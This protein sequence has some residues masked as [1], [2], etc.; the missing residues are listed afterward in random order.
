MRAKRLAAQSTTPLESPRQVELGQ[1]E[2][3][4][5]PVLFLLLAAFGIWIALF[6]RKQRK[7][8]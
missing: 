2:G 1:A 6:L 5:F 4:G 7:A 3:W 8:V